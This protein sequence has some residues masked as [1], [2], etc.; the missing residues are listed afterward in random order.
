MSSCSLEVGEMGVKPDLVWVWSSNFIRFLFKFLCSSSQTVVF[1]ISIWIED[2]CDPNILH[3][4]YC[5]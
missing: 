5:T 3:H 1:S 4:N 2:D